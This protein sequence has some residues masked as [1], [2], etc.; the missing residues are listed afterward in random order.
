M[1]FDILST[2]EVGGCSAKVPADELARA[3]EGLPK[4]VHENLLVGVDTHDDS[5]VYRLKDDLA[6]VLTTDFFP[7]ICSDPYQ[8]GQ[9]AAANA[10][11]DVFAMGGEVAT[12]LNLVMFPSTRIPLEVLEAILRG[13][14]DKVLEAGGVVAGGHTIDDYPP[15]FGLAVTGTV[16][17]DRIITNAAARPGDLLVLTKPVGTGI[18]SAGHRVGEASE[19][20]YQKAIETMKQLNMAGGRIMQEF[21]VQSATDITG[22][23]L[24]GHALKMAEASGVTMRIEADKVPVLSGAYDLLEMGC[25]PCATYKNQDFVEAKADFPDGFD[26]N[27]KLI[28]LDAQTSGGLFISVAADR[29]DEMVSALREEDCPEAVVIGEVIE[30]GQKPIAVS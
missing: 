13:G 1:D 7:P 19:E 10:L 18:L 25:I 21:D 11:S 23:G 2:V 12:A 3:L 22:F 28:L 4:S 6:I 5:G 20:D 9:I 26:F 30:A 16:H 8:F 17:P 24:L 15:K 29:A 14:M 27:T